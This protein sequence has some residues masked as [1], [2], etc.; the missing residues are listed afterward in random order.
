[1]AEMITDGVEADMNFRDTGTPEIRRRE[2]MEDG[3][4]RVMVTKLVVKVRLHDIDLLVVDTS[5]GRV[6]P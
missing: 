4:V 3:E 6:I 5:D 1:M 2:M